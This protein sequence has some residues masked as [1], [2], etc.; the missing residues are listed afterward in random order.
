M[1]EVRNV[2]HAKGTSHT[3]AMFTGAKHEVIDDQLLAVVK[4]V[5][6]VRLFS[7]TGVT[8]LN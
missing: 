6:D 8:S 5:S 4:E 7:P 2:I 3:P 1:T